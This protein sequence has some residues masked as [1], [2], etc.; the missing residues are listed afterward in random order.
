M[1]VQPAGQNEVYDPPTNAA[2]G[3]HVRSL[4][5]YEAIYR[6]SIENSE[7]FW[8][9][10]AREF[11][12]ETPPEHADGSD[13]AAG[14]IRWFEGGRLN[15]AV[16]CV[17][18]HLTSRRDQPAIIWEGDEPGERRT[19]TF[20]QLDVEVRRTAR[21]LRSLG[22]E[23][24]DRVLIYMG[25][26]PEVAVAM[27][28]CARVGAVHSVVFGGFSAQAV[29]DRLIDCDAHIVL[30]QDEGR[31]GGRAISLKHTVDEALEGVERVDH[32]VV[33]RRTGADVRMQPGRDQFWDEIDPGTATDEAA[34]M[35]ATDPLFILYTSGSTGRP[36][37]LL[38]AQAGY[39]VFTA[40]TCR[41]VFDLR[42]GDV[43]ACVAD[44]G[45]IT[46]HSYI[47]YGPLANGATTVMFE[48]TPTHPDPGRYWALVEELGATQ[49]YTAPTA[50]RQIA[51]AGDDWVRQYDRSSLRVLGTVGE[52]IDR[53][54]WHW[55]FDVAGEGRCSIVDTWWQTETGGIMLSGLPGATPMKPGAASLP[56]FGT[57]PVLL[58]EQG[59]LV[60]GR[61]ATGELCFEGSWPGQAATIWG[62]HERYVETYLGAFPGYFRTE[63]IARRD[64]DGYYWIEGRLGD[65]IKVAGHRLGTAE[66]EGALTRHP[67]GAE[68]AVVDYPDA[69]KGAAIHAFV[70][71]AP[72]YEPNEEL[73]DALRNAVRERIGG[74]AVPQ[75]V[76]FVRGLPKTRSGKVMRRVLRGIANGQRA[77]FGDLSTLAD[78]GVVDEIIAG[79][80]IE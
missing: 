31:R 69:I 58:D 16:N 33:Y 18:R 44:I 29:R 47:V 25:M 63:D 17:D 14:R 62:D 10:L 21:M 11:E 54:T 34:V 74:L 1:V 45:W 64:E 5:E 7:A 67:A 55:Y 22:V 61:P 40:A 49:L 3:S 15:V 65:V 77:D 27:L 78:P 4:A 9:D 59:A 30:T 46:G 35:E 57:R 8:L 56:I 24:G 48:S 2:D 26:V 28:A 75:R 41:Y 20:A 12:W 50:L 71:A 52:P 43:Y 6:R 68:A 23:R 37:G 13:L 36:K 73:A 76:Q 66:I 60:E 53:T 72:G 32:V 80:A 51:R 42:D 39:L 70:R 19:L 38:H 79:T